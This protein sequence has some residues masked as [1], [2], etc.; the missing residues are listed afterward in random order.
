MNTKARKIFARLALLTALAFFACAFPFSLLAGTNPMDI[1]AGS[2]L[3]G[4]ADGPLNKAGLNVPYG[5][6]VNS[7]GHLYI[8]DSYNNT[9]RMIANGIMTTVAGGNKG[10]DAYGF[11][12]GGYNDGEALKAR[13]NRP[14]AVAVDKSGVLYV[15]DTGNHAIRK[16]A[17]GKVTTL[18][19]TGQPGYKDGTGKDARFNS[20]AGLVIDAK[21]NL[22]V[23]DTLNQVIRKITPAGVVSTYAGKSG[24]GGYKDGS[25]SSALFNEPSALALDSR[26]DLYIA[27]TGNQLI[28]KVS[29]GEVT[30]VAGS[31]GA[32]LE[33]TGYCRG[34]YRNGPALAAAFNFPKGLT[35]LDNGV[36]IIADTWNSRIRAITG[37]KVI[38]L[39][40]TG[41]YGSRA[42]SLDTAILAAPAGVVYKD[43]LLYIS[44]SDNHLI[45]Q[46]PLDPDNLQARPDY[47][48]PAEEIQIWVDG[49]KLLTDENT[50]PYIFS[51]R[52]ML[53]L[54]AICEK[55]GWSV[56]WAEDGTITVTQE[57]KQKA[58][59]PG[60][61]NLQNKNGFTMTGVRY[62]AESM[63][64]TVDWLPEYRAVSVRSR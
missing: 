19:G 5:L 8:A 31:H 13:F 10:G 53:P 28:R 58:F 55:A 9:V 51:D 22:Y 37:D 38:T 56:D 39:A 35:V 2:G 27:D 3:P 29:S 52:T 16:I 49:E 60:D 62:L 45:W 61:V 57:D 7:K 6:A 24:D 50:R 15:A 40:G 44:D 42:D 26:G 25:V 64:C 11:P 14:R 47:T 17:G 32:L 54:R 20:P 23:A 34:A 36:I 18:A 46:L 63:G 21:G 33:D 4:S 43:K 48:P 41:E 59:L 30:T 1:F 12:R